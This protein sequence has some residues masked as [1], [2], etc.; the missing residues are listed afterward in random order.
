MTGNGTRLSGATW[1]PDP[2][3]A[4]LISGQVNISAQVEL[5]PR[6]DDATCV[7]RSR[8]R[9]HQVPSWWADELADPTH[10]IPPRLNGVDVANP[11][12]LQRRMPERDR[13]APS[14]SSGDGAR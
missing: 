2:V 13:V 4:N 9:R 7:F 12:D 5:G 6:N 3:A 11:H 14:S 8:R 1:E 10:G